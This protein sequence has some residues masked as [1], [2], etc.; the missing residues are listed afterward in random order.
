MMKTKGSQL[1]GQPASSDTGWKDG[2]VSR[3]FRFHCRVI[4]SKSKA[5][6]K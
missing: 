4:V 2:L 3:C 1:F 6:S 5:N